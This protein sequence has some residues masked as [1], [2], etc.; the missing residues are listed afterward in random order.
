MS[1]NI[2]K[3]ETKPILVKN[4]K[5]RYQNA[6][7]Y[8]ID[9]GNKFYENCAYE[10]KQ[11]VDIQTLKGKAMFALTERVEEMKKS[12]QDKIENVKRQF[13]SGIGDSLL[14][15][16]QSLELSIIGLHF[17]GNKIKAIYDKHELFI[18]GFLKKLRR[19]ASRG[20]SEIVEFFDFSMNFGSTVVAFLGEII[21]KVAN[22]LGK[23]VWYTV[24]YLWD[25]FNSNGSV[26]VDL[27]NE[28]GRVAGERAN[29]II[30]VIMRTLY[31]MIAHEVEKRPVLKDYFKFGAETVSYISSVEEDFRDMNSRIDRILGIV[32]NRKGNP[33]RYVSESNSLVKPF[34][35]ISESI[36]E[37]FSAEMRNYDINNILGDFEWFGDESPIKRMK[38][39]H[40]SDEISGG[41][42]RRVFYGETLQSAKLKDFK[43]VEKPKELPNYENKIKEFLKK[44][45]NSDNQMVKE[46]QEEW[47][48]YSKDGQ[49][50]VY[51]YIMIRPLLYS[52]LVY[53]SSQHIRETKINDYS[54]YDTLYNKIHQLQIKNEVSILMDDYFGGVV[55]MN[56]ALSNLSNFLKIDKMF[57]KLKS[58]GFIRRYLDLNDTF[59]V[60]RE[61]NDV[62]QK[63][64]FVEE[65]GV[66]SNDIYFISDDGVL[67][68]Y[69]PLP[70][71]FKSVEKT[72]DEDKLAV[73]HIGEKQGNNVVQAVQLMVDGRNK[74]LV[75]IKKRRQRRVMLLSA[76]QTVIQKLPKKE[77]NK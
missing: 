6:A 76:I 24:E 42:E 18:L 19:A 72:N 77:Q 68:Q 55:D 71:N 17:F 56:Y 20:I 40:V 3:D 35:A 39:Y 16:I 28:T 2:L 61:M 65:S 10:V 14:K 46:I 75:E 58:Y 66:D 53:E 29:G 36:N 73:T 26:F 44:Y 31:D 38:R 30:G 9:G 62:K 49:S 23:F 63:I 48:E 27:L 74:L 34:I 12:I 15:I 67:N 54:K 1:K 41:I 57:E 37:S 21:T 45:E 60:L 11:T 22:S 50:D 59:V 13:K 33:V 51:K 69:S 43:F 32:Q 64:K 52:V 70:Q 47:K 7:Q 4:E 5:N 8:F 25:F